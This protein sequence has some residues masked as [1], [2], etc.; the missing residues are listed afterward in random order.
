MTIAAAEVSNFP[1]KA[2][3]QAQFSFQ[4]IFPIATG[5]LPINPVGT[6]IP[7]GTLPIPTGSLQGVPS[8]VPLFFRPAGPVF[9]TRFGA[10][11]YRLILAPATNGTVR[12]WLELST[13]GPRIFATTKRDIATGYVEFESRSASGTLMDPANGEAIGVEYAAF[14]TGNAAGP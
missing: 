14:A 10:G 13:S 9:L 11:L 6:A 7:T 4:S 2:V 3:Q 12:A 1:P 8:G 5:G